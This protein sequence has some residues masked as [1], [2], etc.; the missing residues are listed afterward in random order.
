MS[1][2]PFPTSRSQFGILVLLS[3]LVVATIAMIGATVA[4]YYAGVH[5]YNEEM[6]DPRKHILG[7]W[8]CADPMTTF[9]A[10]FENDGWV[11]WGIDGFQMKGKYR[12]ATDSTLEVQGDPFEPP[13]KTFD[14]E[15]VI[16]VR[17]VRV[18]CRDDQLVI[19]ASDGSRSRVF[20][21]R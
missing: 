19:E 7:K 13:T 1:R 11:A 6:K 8:K 15:A 3:L 10:T 14:P 5:R 9:Y 4:S 2:I 12:F 17:Q 20:M 16:A 21:R 18:G